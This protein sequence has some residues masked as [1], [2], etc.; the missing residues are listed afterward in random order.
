MA[1]MAEQRNSAG[2]PERPQRFW[3]TRIT[4]VPD[5][6]LHPV[7]FM[8]AAGAYTCKCAGFVS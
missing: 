5:E 3:A 8:L 4:G 6:I 2:G 1:R 7:K